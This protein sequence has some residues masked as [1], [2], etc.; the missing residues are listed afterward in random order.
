MKEFNEDIKYRLALSF[1]KGIGPKHSAKLI[2]IYGSALNIFR[3]NSSVLNKIPYIGETLATGVKDKKI[4]ERAEKEINF[5]QKYN[6]EI[7]SVSDSDYPIKL[8][9]CTD[10]P[11]FIFCKGENTEFKK[12]VSIVG[13]RN[14][15][16]YGKEITENLIKDISENFPETIIISGLAYG[17][18]IC[19]HKSALKYGLST[20][21]VLAHGM[22]KIYPAEHKNIAAEIVRHG[23]LIS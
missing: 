7:I 4:L 22:D 9:E 6:I 15:T 21:A 1:I 20:V 5:C 14:A 12:A 11:Q 8:K 23:E 3:E 18:D 17:V 2:E 19:S 10:A 13:T 16:S